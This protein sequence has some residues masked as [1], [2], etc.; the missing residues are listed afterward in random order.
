MRLPSLKFLKTFQI[1]AKLKSFKAAA[2][3]LFVTP[4][5]VS[6]QIKALEEQ[7]GVTLFERGARGVRTLDLTDAGA[8]YLEHINDIFAKLESVTEQLQIRYGRT[9]IRLNVPPY[10]AN[11]MLLPRLASF[12]QAREET[13]IRIETTFSTPKT[14]P[15]EADLSI[16]VGSGPW[17]GLTV[18]EL[19][20]QRF[21]VA[22]SPTFLIDNPIGRYT[23]LNGK[24]LLVHEERREAWER[25][26]H[27]LGIEPVKPNRLVRLD[28][29]SAVVLAA[30]QG[31][32]VALVPSRLSADR[33]TSGSLI[34][35]FDAE[36]ETNESYVILHRPEDLERDDLQ[37][38]TQWIIEQ[39]RVA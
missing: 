17:E 13:D 3:E 25:W 34:K 6:H 7:L 36:L 5:A 10:F 12:S 19:F 8:H 32:G 26:A 30:E 37:E 33:F 2:Q 21:M 24:T 14:H 29:M 1:A 39:C 35:L 31:V 11:E 38:L 16:V 22:C 20:A 18:H 27:G 28:T 15:P 9:I 23:D 4:S